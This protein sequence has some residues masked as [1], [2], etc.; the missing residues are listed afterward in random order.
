MKVEKLSKGKS[1]KIIIAITIIVLA[2][3]IIYITNSKAK[4]QVTKSVQIVNGNVNYS[5]ADL[6]VL[7]LKV[8]DSKGSKTYNQ[9]ETVPSGSYEVNKDKSYCT[10]PGD[11]TEYKNIPMEY[12]DNK[13]Y[14][15]ITKKGTKCYV[16]LDFKVTA[17]EKTL[18]NLRMTEVNMES[19]GCPTYSNPII[20]GKEESKSLLCKGEDDDGDTYYFRGVV[21]NNWVR[22][23]NT[24]WRI[25]RI[26]GDG[27]IRLI[28]NGTSAGATK[29]GANYGGN[30]S[31][32]SSHNLAE[33][34][35]FKYTTGIR[36]GVSTESAMIYVL[37]IFYNDNFGDGKSLVSYVNKLDH[38][39]GFCGD[40]TS[41]T[42][43]SA[44][45]TNNTGGIGDT[46]TYYG[47]HI[48]INNS[49]QPTFKCP[50]KDNDLY[51]K[52]GATQGNKSLTNPVGLI[53]A[54]E[55]AYI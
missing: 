28:Y 44:Q 40:R 32:N 26:N 3:E 25:I 30:V 16:Y 47:A 22:M 43:S 8:Q 18:D 19:D 35:G 51:T 55:L 42:D 46:A 29:E 39:V 34:V 15:G 21:T 10:Y 54:D 41:T 45:S 2:I 7:A 11:N 20:N 4:Y 53:T 13:V 12:K 14:I 17:S 33:Y 31:F 23:G 27:T 24:Y 37:N 9:A 36:S 52:K 1:K 48:R 49:K 50:S 38:N 6:N 5:L